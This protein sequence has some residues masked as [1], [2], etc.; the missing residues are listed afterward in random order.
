MMPECCDRYGGHVFVFGSNLAG[1]HGRGAAKHALEHHG[2]IYGQGVGRQGMSYAIPTK[3]ATLVALAPHIIREHV[4]DFIDY[5]ME[6]L[7][8]RFYVTR[9]GCGLAGYTDAE[10]GP[11]FANAP[12]NVQLPPQWGIYRH[13]PYFAVA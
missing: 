12:F 6:R 5:A 1:R 8:E 3:G 11:L 9:V 13:P 10:I 2:A 4:R 7:E